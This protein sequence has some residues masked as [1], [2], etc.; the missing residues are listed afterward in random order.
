MSPEAWMR[1][2][3][4]SAVSLTVSESDAG[5]ALGE[6]SSSGVASVAAPAHE[7]RNTES[8]SE[9]ASELT[10]DPT[11]G[12]RR[13]STAIGRVRRDMGSSWARDLIRG[14]RERRSGRARES[15]AR[16]YR[17]TLDSYTPCRDDAMALLWASDPV[18]DARQA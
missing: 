18:D 15:R 8:R 2:C 9:A 13:S 10:S 7:A 3:T 14:R 17:E 11:P 12:W 4:A 6:S 1:R 5:D 16:A